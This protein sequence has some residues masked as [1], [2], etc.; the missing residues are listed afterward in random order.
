MTE[1]F[2]NYDVYTGFYRIKNDLKKKI[3]KFS[4]WKA[5]LMIFL[6][7]KVKYSRLKTRH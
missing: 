7:T 2:G 3:R 4:G 1:I 5:G 6:E